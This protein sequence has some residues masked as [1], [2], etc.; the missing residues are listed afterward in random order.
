MYFND[1]NDRKTGRV[2]AFIDMQ[3]NRTVRFEGFWSPYFEASTTPEPG[4]YFEPTL[5]AEL[6]DAGITIDD[7]DEPDAWSLDVGAPLI[8]RAI[9][10]WRILNIAMILDSF[11]GMKKVGALRPT[12]FSCG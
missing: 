4:D 10:F 2:G 5:L 3:V 1:L 7:R 11:H 9:C 8:C 6:V 12:A